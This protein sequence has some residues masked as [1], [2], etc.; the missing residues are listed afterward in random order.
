VHIL[1]HIQ[2]GSFGSHPLEI[3]KMSWCNTLQLLTIVKAQYNCLVSE[4]CWHS[5][6][7]KAVKWRSYWPFQKR[8]NTSHPKQNFWPFRLKFWYEVLHMETYKNIFFAVQWEQYW[9]PALTLTWSREGQ[10]VRKWFQGH[11]SQLMHITGV[12]QLFVKIYF[13]VPLETMG[14]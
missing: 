4:N 13:L 11:I 8:H 12:K 6:D 5:P 7:L 9:T 14:N 2:G 1:V 10:K 3:S